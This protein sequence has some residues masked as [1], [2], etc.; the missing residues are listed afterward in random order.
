VQGTRVKER[1]L[2]GTRVK[3]RLLPLRPALSSAIKWLSHTLKTKFRP[4]KLRSL[5]SMLQLHATGQPSNLCEVGGPPPHTLGPPARPLALCLRELP[6]SRQAR[7]APTDYHFGRGSLITTPPLERIILVRMCALSMT[8]VWF[9]CSART[10]WPV[11]VR[12]CVSLVCAPHRVCE[13][14]GMVTS[15]SG[16]INGTGIVA[17]ANCTRTGSCATTIAPAADLRQPPNDTA[18]RL[19]LWKWCC[20]LQPAAQTCPRMPPITPNA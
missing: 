19:Q 10:R 11:R 5:G 1:L 20:Y 7:P 18:V 9:A 14:S 13:T 12:A 17:S 6:R 3:S 16:Q 8:S 15:V 2:A 4:A